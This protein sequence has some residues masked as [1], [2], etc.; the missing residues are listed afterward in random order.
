M[1]P[2]NQTLYIIPGD[3]DAGD[4]EEA[5]VAPEPAE[6]V[7]V[8]TVLATTDLSPGTVE[9]LAEHVDFEALDETLSGENDDSVTFDIEDYTVTVASDGTVT[10]ADAE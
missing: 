9:P 8:E 6:K 1:S 7:I 5:W 10:V 3:G 2:E 4:D